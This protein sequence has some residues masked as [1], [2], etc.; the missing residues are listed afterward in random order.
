MYENKYH[1]AFIDGCT[2]QVL[3]YI[4]LDMAYIML[5]A[6]MTSYMNG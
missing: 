5:Q 2:C 6:G 4:I 1:A 3:L